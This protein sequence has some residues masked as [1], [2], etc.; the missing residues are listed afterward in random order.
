MLKQQFEILRGSFGKALD[1]IA[2][3]EHKPVKALKKISEL[4]RKLVQHD[5]AHTPS[6]KKAIGQKA[7]S[8]H[9]KPQQNGNGKSGTAKP[10]GG[11]KGHKGATYRPAPTRF[12]RHAPDRCPRCGMSDLTVAKTSKRNVTEIPPPQKAVT[13]QHVLETCS[14]SVCGLGGIGPEAAP[15]DVDADGNEAVSESPQKT[16][17]E[18][19]LPKRGN[20]GMNV[21]LKVAENFLQRMPHRM[22]ARSLRRHL[23]RM[24]HG[25][26]HNILCMT[27]TNL[28]APARQILD[29]VRL[30]RVLHVDETSL[31]LNG[32]LVW[33][34]IFF[35]P[36]TGNTL[37]VIRPGRGGDVL[38][39]VIHEWDGD[40]RVRRVEPVQEIPR[41][42]VLGAHIAR[43][44]ASR[45]QE[46]RL[47]GGARRAGRPVPRAPVRAPGERIHE[48]TAQA[49]Q[50]PAQARA[51]DPG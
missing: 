20:Y 19:A 13:T 5:N 28:D 34:W 29:L 32:K 17:P 21:I 22:S 1:R 50:L 16:G 39:G 3:L 51:R 26:V 14:C 15:P 18:A 24:S 35:D 45:P 36:E 23:A 48:E 11:Q 25:T 12:E 47:P 40:D 30:A 38:R 6:S 44:Q 2:E 8:Q 27:G 10:R 42:A 41:P 43:D 9:G 7:K 4:E 49:A 37:F 46:S 33:V 31:S